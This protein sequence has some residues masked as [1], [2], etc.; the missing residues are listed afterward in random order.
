VPQRQ[1]GTLVLP[2]SSKATHEYGMSNRREFLEHCF[3]VGSVFAASPL[4]GATT[5]FGSAR[6]RL[7]Q[8]SRAVFDSG[9]IEGRTFADSARKMGMA[10]VAISGDVTALWFNDLYFT[11]RAGSTVIMGLTGASALFCL[12]QLAWDAGHR[13]AM[14]V[15]HRQTAAGVVHHTFRG[16]AEMLD[17][18]LPRARQPEWSAGMAI[19]GASC[20]G[21]ACGQLTHTWH[22]PSH[23][24]RWPEPLVSWVIAPRTLA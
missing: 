4:F 23:R 3:A 10:A 7:L 14:R 5:S 24:S 18:S 13:V 11:W 2:L 22:V 1:D 15:D 6:N 17:H 12:E 8:P 9:F 20:P 16:P 19:L 21:R